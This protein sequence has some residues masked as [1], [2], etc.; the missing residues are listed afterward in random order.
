MISDIVIYLFPMSAME[1]PFSRE[2][3]HLRKGRLLPPDKSLSSLNDTG[4]SDRPKRFGFAKE[5][6]PD[7]EKL[8]SDLTKEIVGEVERSVIQE[9]MK[10][11]LQRE[12][13]GILF[14]KVRLETKKFLEKELYP[15]ILP[16]K[17]LPGGVFPGNAQEIQIEEW[18][19]EEKGKERSELDLSRKIMK[20]NILLLADHLIEDMKRE[21]MRTL[22]DYI[23]HRVMLSSSGMTDMTKQ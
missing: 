13:F 23:F 10:L 14:E 1:Q 11:R 22:K 9:G 18:A 7:A 19:D 6:T 20:E 17:E 21:E 2:S 5:L 3:G 16:K 8:L 4:G 12:G 15:K